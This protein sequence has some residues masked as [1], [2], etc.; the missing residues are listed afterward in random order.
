MFCVQVVDEVGVTSE[1][2][3]GADGE[4]GESAAV[5]RKSVALSDAGLGAS[6]SLP[7]ISTRSVVRVCLSSQIPTALPRMVLL[8]ISMSCPLISIPLLA[9]LDSVLPS[10]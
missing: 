9:L 10:I 6:K 2:I 3:A 5:I 1:P 8:V 7:E 4:A